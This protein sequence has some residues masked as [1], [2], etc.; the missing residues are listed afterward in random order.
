MLR[1][2]PDGNEGFSRHG[3][4][5]GDEGVA[6]RVPQGDSQTSFF[7]AKSYAVMLRYSKQ[8][9]D[10]REVTLREPFDKAQDGPQGDVALG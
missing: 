9:G 1:H 8:G 10:T 7:K 4:S 6:L 3:R 5:G 2:V